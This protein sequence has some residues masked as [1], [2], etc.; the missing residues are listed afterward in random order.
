MLFRQKPLKILLDSRFSMLSG[1]TPS[2]L[3]IVE[4]QVSNIQPAGASCWVVAES[5][6]SSSIE[7][8]P[9]SSPMKAM[10]LHNTPIITDKNYATLG[11]D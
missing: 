9:V 4:H 3:L 6:A 7:R 1:L 11:Y 5:E 8:R 2:L 10:I